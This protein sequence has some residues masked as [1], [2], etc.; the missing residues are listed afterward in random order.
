MPFAVSCPNCTTRLRSANPMKVGN[1]ITCPKCRF[2]FRV[3]PGD[4]VEEV[5]APRANA[6]AGANAPGEYEFDFD[7]PAP[8]PA[9]VRKVSR[10]APAPV[11]AP[12]V[13]AN[14]RP[15]VEPPE[16]KPIRAARRPEPVEEEEE[17]EEEEEVRQ[18]KKKKKPPKAS[19]VLFAVSL[20][21][22]VLIL[23]GGIIYVFMNF[24]SAPAD[25]DLLVYAPADTDLIVGVAVEEMAGQEKIMAFLKAN[26]GKGSSEANSVMT[27]TKLGIEDVS[28]VVLMKGGASSGT[29]IAIKLRIGK[30]LSHDTLVKIKGATEGK[31]GSKPYVRFRDGFACC[32]NARTIL[33]VEME[34]TMQAILSREVQTILIGDTMKDLAAKAGRNGQIYIAA[35]ASSSSL[36]ANMSIVPGIGA[37]GVRGF[38]AFASAGPENVDMGLGFLFSDNLTAQAS[39]K[40]TDKDIADLRAKL[41]DNPNALNALNLGSGMVPFVKELMAKIDTSSDGEMIVVRSTVPMK[42]VEPVLNQMNQGGG[43]MGG[44]GGMQP[45]GK[46]TPPKPGVPPGQAMPKQGGAPAPGI[47]K[48]GVPIAAPPL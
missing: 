12:V 41:E 25:K 32:I 26:V 21:L 30:S 17:E 22:V 46:S 31:V 14:S 3:E 20:L 1:K 33:I 29:V 13:R 27:E 11:V 23:G 19:N 45:P 4:S 38:I 37:P 15:P 9:P 48:G 40:K 35:N 2:E 10:P 36:A 47:P 18:P 6:V 5:A 24:A 28:K 8:A 43:G 16:D 44:M 39:M 7:E 34:P 42:V